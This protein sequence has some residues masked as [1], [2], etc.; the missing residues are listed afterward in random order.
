MG[1]AADA[2]GPVP[3]CDSVSSCVEA[4]FAPATSDGAT[5]FSA[6]PYPILCDFLCA[7][8]IGTQRETEF[9]IAA[10]QEKSL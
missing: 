8:S 2:L 5:A 4:A 6:E 10:K 3:V 1:T 9:T 7:S